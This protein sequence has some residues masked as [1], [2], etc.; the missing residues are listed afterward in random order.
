MD[1][2]NTHDLDMSRPAAADLFIG[3]VWRLT[4]RISDVGANDSGSLPEHFLGTQKQPI[5]KMA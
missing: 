2:K 1:R 4:T 5:P 3:R